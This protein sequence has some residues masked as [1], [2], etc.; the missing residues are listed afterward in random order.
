MATIHKFGLISYQTAQNRFAYHAHSGYLDDIRELKSHNATY[1]F[2]PPQAQPQART[3]E[4]VPLYTPMYPQFGESPFGVDLNHG[5]VRRCYSHPVFVFDLIHILLY[6]TPPPGPLIFAPL[7][8]YWQ[9]LTSDAPIN[10]PHPKLDYLLWFNPANPLVQWEPQYQRWR[11]N[12]TVSASERAN[13][14]AAARHHKKTGQRP[15]VPKSD[16]PMTLQTTFTP[17]NYLRALESLQEFRYDA[18]AIDPS[19]DP[20]AKHLS[21]LPYAPR[22]TCRITG[23]PRPETLYEALVCH[24]WASNPDRAF[25]PTH[26]PE[27]TINQSVIDSLPEIDL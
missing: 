18:C 4:Y 2:V 20:Y 14:R 9:F 3:R 16:K 17:W 21:T 13:P 1:L 11:I 8:P 10:L 19:T 26:V 5:L 22:Q 6:R 23:E 24:T 15:R 25:D 7:S 27:R 12:H